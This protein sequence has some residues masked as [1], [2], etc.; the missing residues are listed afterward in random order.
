MSVFFA[1]WLVVAVVMNL[2]IC[3]R[4]SERGLPNLSIKF[5]FFFV[6]VGGILLAYHHYVA[7][8]PL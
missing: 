6:A 1:I 7:H 2:Y 4:W 3:W 8:Q 5:A